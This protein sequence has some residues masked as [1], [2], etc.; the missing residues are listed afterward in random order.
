MTM[1]TKLSIFSCRRKSKKDNEEAD[2]PYHDV[3]SYE[4]KESKFGDIFV[5]VVIGNI[6]D[7]KSDAIV[8]TV[9]ENLN[10]DSSVAK[11]IA[12]AG[13]DAIRQELQNIISNNLGGQLEMSER[14]STS[15]G[16]L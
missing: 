11:A 2:L 16:N 12:D 5:T 10:C 1:G 4:G 14:V 9:D 7:E 8:S 13:G 6:A 3:L 15:G